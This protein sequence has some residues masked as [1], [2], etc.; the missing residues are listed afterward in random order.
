MTDKELQEIEKSLNFPNKTEI[1]GEEVIFYMVSHDE[2]T[3]LI[4]EVRRLNEERQKEV[5]FLNE[6][7]PLTEKLIKQNQRYKQ[8]LEEI[9][10]T[11]DFDHPYNRLYARIEIAKKALKGEILNE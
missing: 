2:F 4:A 3:A 9:V 7:Q 6:A 1:N 11:S 8:A 5:E 10:D